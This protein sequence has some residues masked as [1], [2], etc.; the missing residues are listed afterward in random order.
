MVLIQTQSMVQ[1]SMSEKS[2]TVPHETEKDHRRRHQQ[3]RKGMKAALRKRNATKL[4]KYF[5]MKRSIKWYVELL[6][7]VDT[8]IEMFIRERTEPFD[9]NCSCN[10]LMCTELLGHALIFSVV[11]EMDSAGKLAR[12]LTNL[13]L[14]SENIESINC[15]INY[16]FCRCCC[17]GGSHRLNMCGHL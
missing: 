7:T 14:F 11:R 15:F 8:S 2:R 1:R 17:N 6:F 10:R 3:R 4:F 13:T 9:P 5:A 12:L 16:H